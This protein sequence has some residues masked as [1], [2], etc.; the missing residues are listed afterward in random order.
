MK[1]KLK[2][3]LKRK[4]FAL[5]KESR[6]EVDKVETDDCGNYCARVYVYNIEKLKK[7]EQ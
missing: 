6:V 4:G 3:E 2:K 5:T 7:S 1:E